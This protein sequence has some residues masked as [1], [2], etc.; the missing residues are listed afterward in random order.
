M[1]PA[2]RVAAG[3]VH[4][5]SPSRSEH[6]PDSP[7]QSLPRAQLAQELTGWMPLW[8][9]G[10]RCCSGE[11]GSYLTLPVWS[12]GD[13]RA[14]RG[15]LRGGVGRPACW[16]Q[17]RPSLDLAQPLLAGRRGQVT[18][19]PLSLSFPVCKGAV[20]EDDLQ[21]SPSTNHPTCSAQKKKQNSLSLY[22]R[23]IS[24]HIQ[25]RVCLVGFFK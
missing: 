18:I 12:G 2:A 11:G 7:R 10:D 17:A 9:E 20:G 5:S 21:V 22:N 13:G 6:T 8:P 14:G 23:Y 24:T 25:K 15:L 19:Y 4:L 3:Q 16:K 1:W